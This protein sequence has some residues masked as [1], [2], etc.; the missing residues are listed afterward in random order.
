MS[1]RLFVAVLGAVVLACLFGAPAAIA[2]TFTPESGGSPNADDIDT[3]YK[4]TLYVGIVIFLLVEGTLIWS[5]VRYRARRGGQGRRRSAATP[6]SR[7][8]G[9]SAPRPSSSCSRS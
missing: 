2:D 7:S 3:L 1:R 8:A 6:R 4:I 5:L 9:R